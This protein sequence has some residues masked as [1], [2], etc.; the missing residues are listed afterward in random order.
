MAFLA[1]GCAAAVQL[2]QH[3]LA[4]HDSA[5][6]R[7]A[8][9]RGSQSGGLRKRNSCSNTVTCSVPGEI[10]QASVGLNIIG[11]RTG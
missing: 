2:Q 5:K 8:L 4:K 7:A 9:L 3:Y 6:S 11:L 1:A 10:T